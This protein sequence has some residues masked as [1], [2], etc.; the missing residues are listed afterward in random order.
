MNIHWGYV[1][2]NEG[3]E[4]QQVRVLVGTT[5]E[6]LENQARYLGLRLRSDDYTDY[7]SLQDWEQEVEW[8]LENEE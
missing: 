5:Q 6:G 2:Q 3:T 4:N 7:E 1:I 8:E